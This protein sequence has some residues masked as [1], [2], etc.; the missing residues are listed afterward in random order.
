MDSEMRRGVYP[1][2]EKPEE[3]WI[4][5]SNSIMQIASPIPGQRNTQEVYLV[6]L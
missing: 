4:A 5:I 2:R 6:K 3:A 1:L